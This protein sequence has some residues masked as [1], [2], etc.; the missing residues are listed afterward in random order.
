MEGRTAK[1]FLR[2]EKERVDRTPLAQYARSSI[3]GSVDTL[4][5]IMSAVH[6]GYSVCDDKASVG[7]IQRRCDTDEMRYG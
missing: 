1:P 3:L 2:D 5:L 4:R 7:S 6:N